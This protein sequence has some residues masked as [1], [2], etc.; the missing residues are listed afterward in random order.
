MD[1]YT[2]HWLAGTIGSA[3][4]YIALAY[5][6]PREEA[7]T[8]VLF[9]VSL[10]VLYAYLYGLF[11]H[12]KKIGLGIATAIG[13]RALLL[14]ALPELS[15]DYFRFVW[16]GTI[17]NMGLNPYQLVPNEFIESTDN[18]ML[19]SLFPQLNS[20]T[21]H[22]VYPPINQFV[23]AVAAFFFPASLFGQVVV[24]KLF[25]LLTEGLTIYLL[26]SLLRYFKKPA[27]LVFLYAFN[28]I[29]VVEL[30]GNLHFEGVMLC[31]VLLTIWLVKNH[32]SF[33]SGLALSIGVCTKFWPAVFVPFF[34]RKLGWR[35][36]L[37]FTFA[38]G[39][40]SLL[41]FSPFLY[42]ETFTDLFSSIRL[43]F[44][45]FEFN[46]SVYYLGWLFSDICEMENVFK[47][48]PLIL[49]SL[50]LSIV[51]VLFILQKER[52]NIFTFLLLVLGSYFFLATTV[53]PW[54][55]VP[56]I[57]LSIFTKYRFPILWSVLI[58]VTYLTYG[59]ADYQQPFLFIFLEYLLL[60]MFMLMEFLGM[61]SKAWRQLMQKQ[62]LRRGQI[63]VD[64]IK[65]LLEKEEKILDIGSGNGAVVHLLRKEGFDVTG[66]DVVAKSKMEDVQPI[67][68]SG[69]KLPFKDKEFDTVLLLTML[70]HTPN[71]DAILKEAQRVGKRLI[72][73]EDVYTNPPQL[74][75]TKRVDALVNWEFWGHPHTNRTTIGWKE[76]LDEIGFNLAYSKEEKFLIFFRQVTILATPPPLADD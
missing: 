5:Y 41:F 15:D 17:T 1:R 4:L 43:Y 54:Y 45:Y 58:V 20:Q 36:G 13:F 3:A 2:W 18:E 11:R 29:V 34:W 72:V 48:H 38:V 39:F 37:K 8:V 9:F 71:P 28:P 32:G 7:N 68:S 70:H 56:L 51:F 66:T 46:A 55:I 60:F 19:K 64:R 62:I 67:V 6:T 22:T 44:R 27:Y 61:P 23:F 49:P 74:W 33:S 12:T 26:L 25:L 40:I 65:G 42:P 53:H 75:L 21:F 57:G 24:M 47:T 50:F 59:S 63:K 73:M 30:V 10:F 76:T 16:D 35:S 69:D 52:S 14:F 31:S